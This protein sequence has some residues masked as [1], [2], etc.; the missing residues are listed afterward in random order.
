VCVCVCV[1]VDGVIFFMLL[2]GH[3]EGR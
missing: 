1:V 2:V 3:Q